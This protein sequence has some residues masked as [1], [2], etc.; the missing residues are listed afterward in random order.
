MKIE[1]LGELKTVMSNPHGKH[2]YFGWPTV[3]RLQNGKIA[4]VASGYRL[5]HVCPFGKAV[6]C[7]SED[8]GESFTRPAPV[9][10]TPLDDR[11]GGIM[12]FGESG[13]C[14]TSFNNSVEF[15][16]GYAE[17]YTKNKYSLAYLDTV[18]E[19]EEKAALGVTFRISNDCGVTF[20]PIRHSPVTSPHGPNELSDGTV[21]WVGYTWGW[22]STELDGT[23][24]KAYRMD[25]ATGEMTHVGDIPDIPSGISMCEPHMAEASDGTLITHIRCEDGSNGTTGDKKFTLFQ[26]ESHD[27]GKTWTAPH[28]ILSNLGGAPAHILRTGSG[29]LISSYGYRAAP[30]GIRMA[31]SDD[32]GKTWDFD[33]EINVNGVTYDI[34]YPSTVELTDGSF[35]TVFYAHVEKGAPATILGQRWR[36]V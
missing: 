29:R 24:L 25:P 4:A 33:H 13:V 10:D 2:N 35:F 15:Q 14:V 30:Y 8:E 34:G 9:I 32:C 21:L 12:T 27:G 26:T 7:Y 16:R 23:K 31:Y 18:T 5:D 1:L 22:R 36:F 11:D 28:Q 3:C 19:A 17:K 20:G 6:I